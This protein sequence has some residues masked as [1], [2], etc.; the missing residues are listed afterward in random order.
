MVT[1]SE[2]RGGITA[3]LSLQAGVA[4]TSEMAASA[5]TCA[6][7]LLSSVRFEAS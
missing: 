6:R 3:V 4:Y 2:P 7:S 5:R 1:S